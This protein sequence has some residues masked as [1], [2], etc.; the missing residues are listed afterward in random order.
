MK[1]AERARAQRLLPVAYIQVN[2]AV[3]GDAKYSVTRAG[4]TYLFVNADAKKLYVANP[5][6]FMVG[7]HGSWCRDGDG[8][9]TEGEE[10]SDAVHRSRR[11]HP[12][13]LERRGEV[14]YV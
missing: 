12:P 2:K 5:A 9:G 13:V 11:R 1:H 6:K 14:V 7:F 4:H 10:R 8:D 3:K